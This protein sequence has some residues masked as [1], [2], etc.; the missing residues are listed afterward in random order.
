MSGLLVE[1]GPPL[2]GQYPGRG[3]SRLVM[4][5]SRLVLSS[6]HKPLLCPVSRL[7]LACSR[8]DLHC[9]SGSLRLHCTAS[10]R[11]LAVTL[12]LPVGWHPTVPRRGLAPHLTGVSACLSILPD[13]HT[14]PRLCPV[15][16]LHCLRG[17]RQ[18]LGPM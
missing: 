4:F 8:S 10:L 14:P 6:S 7:G 13:R 3:K 11:S 5:L 15:V 9:P 16:V 2:L 1:V 17:C 12:L 18:R